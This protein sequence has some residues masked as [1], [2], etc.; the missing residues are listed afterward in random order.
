[1]A[2]A[3]GASVDAGGISADATVHGD[4]ARL[5]GNYV[6]KLGR[7]G[8]FGFSAPNAAL[9]GPFSGDFSRSPITF[10]AQGN[11]KAPSASVDARTRKSIV[12]VAPGLG[13]TPLGPLMDGAKHGLD[14]ALTR[15]ALDAPLSFTWAN[16]KGRLSASGAGALTAASGAR[17][18]IAP[19]SDA[20]PSAGIGLPNGLLDGGALIETAGG[21]LPQAKITITD[22]RTAMNEFALKGRAQIAS[23]QAG[24]SS[25]RSN[26]MNFDIKTKAGIGDARIKGDITITGPLAGMRLV[27]ATTP[28]DL[29]AH[30]NNGF[31]ASPANGMCQEIRTTRIEAAGLVFDKATLP[32]CPADGGFF[33]AT[34][35][36]GN[37]SGGFYINAL[38][39][40]GRMDGAPVR[41]AKL[42]IGGINSQ[43]G[44]GPAGMRLDTTVNAP[45]LLINWDT[46]RTVSVRGK[47]VTAN[48]LTGDSWRVTGALSDVW[49]EDS[50]APTRVEKF[51]GAL[52]IEPKGDDAVLR[53]TNGA[54]R[55]FDWHDKR[56]VQP[57]ALRGVN[58]VMANGIV[59]GKGDIRLE[60][61]DAFLGQ[62]TLKH[63][64]ASGKGD[65]AAT[66]RGL[67]FSPVLKPYE[68]SETLLSVAGPLDA[69]IGAHWSGN[70]FLTD[71]KFSF[72]NLNMATAALGPMEGVSGVVSFNDF[73]TLSTPPHQ[74]V[75]V[76]RINPGIEV[77]NGVFLFQM[78]PDLNVAL[79]SAVWPFAGGK[80]SVLPTTFDFNSKVTRLTLDLTDIDVNELVKQLNAKDLSATGKVEGSFPLIF[81]G[82][83]GRIENGRLEAAP[84]GGTIQYNSD[85]GQTGVAQLAFDALRSFRYDNLTLALDGD[86]DKE[87]ISSIA[88]S[89]VNREPVKQSA[90][91]GSVKLV[92][93]PFK[94]NVKV[95]APFMALS[96]TAA[97]VTDARGLLNGTEPDVEV[98]ATPQTPPENKPK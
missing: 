40:N 34:D 1:L 81:E 71:A 57:M 85:F 74:R 73:A 89:G 32:V 41:P 30:W 82:G 98:T 83:K 11:L 37:Y 6:A 53:V 3:K 2:S 96:R 18:A 77:T 95:R 13:G 80:L 64:L 86:L 51:N 49:V 76:A 75:T 68:I 84:G 63:D 44:G 93:I 56:I 28:L 29:V 22:L 70:D 10:T 35:A 7:G 72:Q 65:A 38:T 79:E 33:A 87:I 39:L 21:G 17:I 5:S 60:K 69:D 20:G 14:R 16:D 97:S 54:G 31:R 19:L 43:L 36:K 61:P 62:F 78:K 94:F 50:T 92:G 47:T 9:D 27:D 8:A 55:V 88:F 12:D 90:G 58:V 46:T 23:W 66:S 26:A 15:F 25:A 45:A 67:L 48:L 59:T 52:I 42:S 91:P 24:D 4:N